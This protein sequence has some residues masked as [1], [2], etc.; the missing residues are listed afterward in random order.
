MTRYRVKVY[1]M[2]DRDEAAAR[3]A[4]REKQIESPE[5]TDGYV[6]GTV[7]KKWFPR[8]K[9]QGLIVTA[10]E[11]L[12]GSKSQ[13]QSGAGE[14][15]ALAG[16]LGVGRPG[17]AIFS[18]SERIVR[19]DTRS[20][21]AK[22]VLSQDSKRTQY[23][24]VRFR[25][26]LTPRRLAE[27]KTLRVA[28][29]ERITRNRYTARIAPSQIK[30]VA[31]LPF[32]DWLRLYEFSDT[33]RGDDEVAGDLDLK[34]TA[35]SKTLAKRTVI[36]P[37]A[38]KPPSRMA[39]FSVRAHRPK[40]IGDIV[41][42]LA[43]RKLK[44]LWA[45][46]ST[47]RI[48]L[49]APSRELEALA[50]IPSVAAVEEVRPPQLLDEC[51]REIIG[52]DAMHTGNALSSLTG[53]G[54]LIGIADTGL[55]QSHPDFRG[56]IKAAESL[57][58]PGDTSDPEGHGTHVAGC[59]AG[60]GKASGGAV[61]GAAPAAKIY[62][63]SLLDK[64]GG[65]GGL[66]K[67]L[68]TLFKQAYAKG[69][70]IHNNSWGAFSFARYSSNAL[71]A[72]RFIVKHPDMLIVF[73]AGNDGTAVP[74]A[75]GS[76]MSSV[77]GY[78][79]WPSVAEPAVAK[80]AL[81]VGASRSSRA[82]GGF[83]EL[84]WGMAWP[85]RYPDSPIGDELISSDPHCLAAFSS[86]GPSIDNRIK[87][88]V[89]AP[90]TDIAAARSKDAPLRK[91]W[92][93]YPKNDHYA[94]MGGTSMA[95]PYVA[96]CAALVREWYRK[97]RKYKGPSAALVKATLINGTTQ[98]TGLDAK[99]PPKGYPNFHQGFGR[100]DMVN[101]LPNPQAA[102]LDL[103]HFDSW[104]HYRGAI[105][106]SG[107]RAR[108]SLKAGSRRDLRFCLAWT[109][110]ACHSL[111]N[112]LTLLVD[113]G[114]DGRWIGNDGAVS[115]IRVSGAL[116]DPHN[117]VQVVRVLNPVPGNYTIVITADTLLFPPQH[118]ALVITGEFQSPLTKI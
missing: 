99:A 48:A 52:L 79:D 56:R 2:H 95:A 31:S 50:R 103:V 85:E 33:L 1:F 105:R 100:V 19:S 77:S 97:A 86:R 27:L 24:L 22:K 113:D 20:N 59:A 110:P 83:S 87:P 17:P 106:E 104:T 73:A 51:V 45:G 71:E 6:L 66:P 67:D 80:N 41:K 37:A 34:G 14:L 47:L 91:F 29:T 13:E 36:H 115:T 43:R 65:L 116:A 9:K 16:S 75:R 21:P 112:V 5:W 25:G 38:D 63:Q 39:I 57:G 84:K 82:S 49:R 94:F 11:H 26:P 10:L 92:G 55:D 7:E 44:P 64:N 23:Y 69:V 18:H 35:V 76:A 72:D 118:F 70:R 78:V 42:W 102:G 4:V 3:A 60:D 88:D 8:L 30:T 101:T 40:D 117:N 89:V 15:A 109:D 74:R 53:S 62:F 114:G 32:V 61:R 90:G 96:G 98:L 81:T 58:R 12:T 28:V 93:A 68:T 108:F 54:E 46:K 107:H 111:Q